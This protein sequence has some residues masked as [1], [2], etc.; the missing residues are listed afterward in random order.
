M[1]CVPDSEDPPRPATPCS[2]WA[3]T[4]GKI[5]AMRQRWE[6]GEAIHHPDDCKRKL[7]R[8][9]DHWDERLTEGGVDK[10]H[11]RD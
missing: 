2:H 7:I 5:E 4:A 6:A 10:R 11:G 1:I 3:V 8:F 9:V